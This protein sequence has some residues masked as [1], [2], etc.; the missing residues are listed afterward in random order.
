[1]IETLVRKNIQ[2]LK[3]YRCARDIYDTGILLD[4]NENSF[5][6]VVP[7][8]GEEINRY[9]DPHQTAMRQLLGEYINV[10][11]KNL[12]FGV[13]SDEVIDLLIRIF[14]DP[15]QDR[16]LIAEPTY[17][18]YQVC[19]DINNVA[20]D[21]VMLNDDFSIDIQKTLESVT[22]DTKIIF[23]CSPNNPTANVHAT[24]TIAEILDNT[25]CIVAVDEAYIDFAEKDDSCLQLLNNYPKLVIMRTFS[26]AWGLAGIRLGY[27]IANKI[28]IDYLFKVKAPYNINTLTREVFYAAFKNL[29]KKEQ[30]IAAIIAEREYLIQELS[31]IPQIE[32]IYPT[33]TNYVLFK[34]FNAAI[35]Q[36]DIA[37]K[38]VIIRDR[39][40]QPKLMDCLRIT[41]GTREE[42]NKFLSALAE[43]LSQAK[44]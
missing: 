9:P 30:M 38:G 11:P 17:G 31:K 27:C 5:G 22:P 36:K 4:A 20:T 37:E 6:S 1:M 7:H 8:Q 40:G 35:I 25:N 13:G 21:F 34:V 10:D 24:D 39:S 44:E 42:N 19:A 2:S 43:V 26:K 15:G 32:K 23:F 28:I 41:V 16:I 3:P 29:D 33:S 14:C 12:F 18:M